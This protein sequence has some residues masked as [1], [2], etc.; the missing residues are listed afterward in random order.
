MKTSQAK[1]INPHAHIKITSDYDASAGCRLQH[2]RRMKRL[3]QESHRR[4]FNGED[5]QAV[6]ID[7]AES[8]GIAFEDEDYTTLQ[9]SPDPSCNCGFCETAEWRD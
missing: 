4:Q 1:I 7:L 8:N 6:S 2:E 5:F 9:S 3:L